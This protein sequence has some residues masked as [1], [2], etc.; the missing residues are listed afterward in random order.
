MTTIGLNSGKCVWMEESPGRGVCPQTAVRLEWN[1][2]YTEGEYDRDAEVNGVP[3]TG[4]STRSVDTQGRGVCP[5]TAV[6]PILNILYTGGEYDRDAEVN[7]ALG[8][9]RP[10]QKTAVRLEW[11]TC[12]PKANT[13]GAP[14]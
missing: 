5:Q 9:E 1:I 8:T 7:G 13:I 4:R 14:K 3:G 10:T 6:R 12:I 11:N 2:L